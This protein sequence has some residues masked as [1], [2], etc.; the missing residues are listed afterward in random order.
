MT[1]ISASDRDETPN[2]ELSINW[3]KSKFYKNRVII[4]TVPEEWKKTFVLEPIIRS[5]KVLLSEDWESMLFGRDIPSSRSGS[6]FGTVKVGDALL[7]PGNCGDC[8]ATPLDR[9]TFDSVELCLT[10]TDLS[11]DPA[12]LPEVT[13]DERN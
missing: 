3:G 11:T 2:L 10:V 7:P 4:E 5:R 13:R 8:E 1:N 12:Q 9:E 6:V